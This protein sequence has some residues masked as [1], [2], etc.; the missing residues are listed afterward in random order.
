MEPRAEE[1]V[2]DDVAVEPLVCLPARR[3]Q[4]LERDP[5]IAAVRAASAH[6]AERLRVRKVAQ[7]LLRYCPSRPLH[8]L[9][10]VVPG[11][12]VLHLGRRVERYLHR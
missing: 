2:D 7:R 12:R 5:G 1:P 9:A 8:E 4:R 10:D 6:G 11:L 3:A